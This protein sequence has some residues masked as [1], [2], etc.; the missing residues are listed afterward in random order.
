M[1]ANG[2]NQIDEVYLYQHDDYLCEAKKIVKYNTSHAEWTDAD[3]EAM[4]EQA[5]YIAQFDRMIKDGRE[6]ISRVQLMQNLDQY[7]TIEVETAKPET[8]TEQYFDHDE[9][10]EA[11][12]AEWGLNSL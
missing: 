10:F 6:K 2:E 9:S 8:A 7:A 12:A 4:T 11:D 1:N 5:K 3:T